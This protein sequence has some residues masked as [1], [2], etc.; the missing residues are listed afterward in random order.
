MYRSERRCGQGD[1]E[2]RVLEHAGVDSLAAADPG[3][4]EL[5]GVLL[6]EA[7]ARRADAGPPV[8]AGDDQSAVGQL[9]GGAVQ[10]HP[11]KA[12]R[13]G[14]KA[15]PVDLGEDR[16]PVGGGGHHGFLRRAASWASSAMAS[17]SR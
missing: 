2:Q 5:E 1:E 10:S 3:R 17:S 7:G 13:V 11:P 4:H 14:A 6:I 9:A 8:L 12:D 16:A 15:G